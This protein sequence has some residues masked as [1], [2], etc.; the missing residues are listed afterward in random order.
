MNK[1]EQTKKTR[2]NIDS[3][4]HV[5]LQTH[6][7][8]IEVNRYVVTRWYETPFFTSSVSVPCMQWMS[9]SARTW[10]GPV[11]LRRIARRAIGKKAG[12]PIGFIRLTSVDS[13]APTMAGT[14]GARVVRCAACTREFRYEWKALLGI[15]SDNVTSWIGE[16]EK[17]PIQF[18]FVRI[19]LKLK[20][21]ESFK[22]CIKCFL[23]LFKT[24]IYS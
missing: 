5:R 19:W 2:E 16:N 3:N 21:I 23:I 14:N 7:I 12:F 24:H 1:A 6:K 10:L 15:A 20:M 18:A 13:V 22:F 8:S 9:A 17:R 4:L 11:S